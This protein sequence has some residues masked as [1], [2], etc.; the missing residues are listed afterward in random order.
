LRK[1]LYLCADN[2][3][4]IARHF[5][6][7]D[8]ILDSDETGRSFR[9]SLIISRN[10]LK[11]NRAKSY[12]RKQRRNFIGYFALAVN[13]KLQ[14]VDRK[15]RI[16][17][18]RKTVSYFLDFLST[19]ETAQLLLT[20][21]YANRYFSLILHAHCLFVTIPN[22]WKK[23]ALRTITKLTS[24]FLFFKICTKRSKT[25]LAYERFAA[26]VRMLAIN[27][28]KKRYTRTRKL[29]ELAKK[30]FARVQTA[31]RNYDAARMY[32]DNHD[33]GR[34]ICGIV[35]YNRILI[36]AFRELQNLGVSGNH[37]L[38]A[39]H[40]YLAAHFERKNRGARKSKSRFKNYKIHFQ[41]QP[42]GICCPNAPTSRASRLFKD[43][44]IE[45]FIGDSHAIIYGDPRPRF[46]V[47]APVLCGNGVAVFAR[48]VETSQQVWSAEA[49]YPGNAGLPRILP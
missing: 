3:S 37:H 2:P 46:G 8:E 12:C 17:G 44:G 33:G 45:Y 20:L 21:S 43:A 42:R 10:N 48:D 39:T 27:C 49:G 47:H 1:L 34:S 36:N 22:F 6:L 5:R 38:G 18:K 7:G 41:R 29:L 24:R 13:Q 4:R 23:M 40:G 35:K 9:R 26:A 32:V 11:A 15:C 28:S 16:V 25:R 30:E 19:I 31:A 14:E